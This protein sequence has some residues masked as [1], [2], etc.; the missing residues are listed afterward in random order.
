[1]FVILYSFIAL[2][3][4]AIVFIALKTPAF[5]FLVATFLNKD[6]MYLVG[7]DR[8]AEF[9]L[10]TK[11]HG[12]A[13]VKNIGIFN[14]TEN[15]STLEK[16][17]K[18]AIYFAFRDFAATLDPTYPAIIQ[19]LRENGYKISTID[20]IQELL[21]KIKNGLKENQ[22]LGIQPFKTYRIHD[23]ENM[24]P[25]NLDPTFI[26]SQVQ[27]ELN[28]FNKMIKGTNQV[29]QGLVVLI[30]VAAVAIF[31]LNKAFKG[32]ISTSECSLICSSVGGAIKETV[33]NATA[34]VA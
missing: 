24:F 15:S 9:K 25:L 12:S 31:I 27:G 4:L 32:Q 18:T 19:E 30:V 11:K 28:K 7:K 10:I 26:E 20:D 22:N 34:L 23:M 21:L 6:I 2:E 5:T 17:T 3:T 14:L 16:K 8:R 13:V 29:L 1:M 33:V